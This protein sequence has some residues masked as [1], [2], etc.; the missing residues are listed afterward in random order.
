MEAAEHVVVH[1]H[2]RS[3]DLVAVTQR[4]GLELRHIVLLLK[5]PLARES[6]GHDVGVHEEPFQLKRQP[7]RRNVVPTRGA[8]ERQFKRLFVCGAKLFEALEVELKNRGIAGT[9]HGSFD[10]LPHVT[11]PRTHRREQRRFVGHRFL[12]PQ[13]RRKANEKTA[14]EE[15]R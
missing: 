6:N 14:E 7:L 2:Q 12:G 4:E 10:L 1:E 8:R 15:S 11:R 13:A 5:S 9:L 3:H